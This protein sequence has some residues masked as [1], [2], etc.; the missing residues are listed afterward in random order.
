MVTSTLG[1][2][3]TIGKEMG[4]KP[5]I[6][7]SNINFLNSIKPTDL[8]QFKINGRTK[9]IMGANKVITNKISPFKLK[10]RMNL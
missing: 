1:K 7:K 6:A 4:N 2:V 9:L 5:Q 8:N 3:K 10:L